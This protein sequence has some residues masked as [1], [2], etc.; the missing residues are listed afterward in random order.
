MKYRACEISANG[1]IEQGYRFHA[2]TPSPN[3]NWLMACAIVEAQDGRLKTVYIEDLRFTDR[4]ER[5]NDRAG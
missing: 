1:T 5:S 2:Y 4:E 3:D